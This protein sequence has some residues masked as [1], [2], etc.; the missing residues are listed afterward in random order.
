MKSKPGTFIVQTQAINI[1]IG[2]IYLQH[3]NPIIFRGE[4]HAGRDGEKQ[5]IW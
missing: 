2:P 1:C 5:S 3:L 4:L